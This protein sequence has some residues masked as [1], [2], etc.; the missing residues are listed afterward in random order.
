MDSSDGPVRIG[1]DSIWCQTHACWIG[2]S[3]GS[4]LRGAQEI[5]AQVFM[6]GVDGVNL[7]RPG[8]RQLSNT[9]P[10][11]TIRFSLCQPSRTH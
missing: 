6:C 10:T 8:N 2:E 7:N 9:C 4:R 1:S 3:I 5:C 11:K